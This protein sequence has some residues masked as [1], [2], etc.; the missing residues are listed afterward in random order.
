MISKYN[1]KC[2]HCG[3][4]TKAGVDQYDIDTK[5][6]YHEACEPQ[7]LPFDSAEDDELADRLGFRKVE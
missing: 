6:S 4:P 1:G 3:Q 5:R 2:A 7:P